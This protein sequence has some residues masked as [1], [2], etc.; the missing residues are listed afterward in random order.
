MRILFWS[1]NF[2]PLIGGAEVLAMR[3][4]P[5][6]RERGHEFIV[7]TSQRPPNSPRKDNYRGIPVYRFP[8]RENIGDIDGLTEIRQ[9]V[10]KLKQSF[11]PD[12]IH[13][14]DIDRHHFF[15]LITAHAYP[16]P[17]LVTLHLV[18]SGEAVGR[19]SWRRRLIDNADWVTCVSKTMLTEMRRLVPE[20]GS[21]SSVLYNGLEVNCRHPDPLPIH[22]PQI[23]CLGRLQ[24]RKGFDVA[25]AAFASISS[26]YSRVRLIIAG[27]GPERPKLEQQASKL[28]LKDIV[29]FVGWVAPEAVPSLINRTTIVVMPSQ[30]EGLPLVALEAALMARPVVATHVG[31][32][33]EV[34]VDRE[35][36]LL[37]ENGDAGGL[38][39]A[40]AYLLDHPE[41]AIQMGQMARQRAQE[42]FSFGRWVDAYDVLYRKLC[43]GAAD[44]SSLKIEN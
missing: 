13:I 17:V 10:A 30:N 14:N 40:I 6:L 32:L 33:P 43:S 27:D 29:H 9:Q 39:E 12:L 5:A 19:E 11:A 44:G 42:L 31:G 18:F 24:G 20:I 36:G 23:L 35:T 34:V 38:A 16:A 22:T 7:V 15:H 28:G 4:L 26:R 8:F 21:H 41:T 3:L 37:V 1:G 2:W 25:L